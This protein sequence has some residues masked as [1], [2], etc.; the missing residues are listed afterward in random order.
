MRRELRALAAQ[1]PTTDDVKRLV[2][3]KV[4][5][6][7]LSDIVGTFVDR[8]LSDYVG[9]HVNR[10]RDDILESIKATFDVDPSL[11]ADM[12]GVC[13]W[14]GGWVGGWVVGWVAG[15]WWLVWCLWVMVL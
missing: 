11:R 7:R 10:I 5:A 1:V 8:N 14:V 4:D 3:R 2:E 12:S 6:T 9:L 13:G 15:G